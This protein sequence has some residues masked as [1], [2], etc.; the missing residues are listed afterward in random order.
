[1]CTFVQVPLALHYLG[2]EAYGFWVT[3]FSIVLVLNSVDFGLGVGMQHAMAKA[4]GRDDFDSMRRTFWTGA[5]VLSLLGLAVLL[6][7]IPLAQLGSWADVLQIRETRLRADVANA[8]SISV[9]AFVIGLPFNAVS[10]LAA[11]MQRGWIHAG[12]IAAGSGISLA[13]VAAAA[14]GRWGFLW[15][16]AASLLV[17]AIQ[18]LGLTVHLLRTLHWTPRPTSLAPAA[19][20]R[21]MLRSSLYFAFPQ[22]G[23]VLVQSVPAIAISVAAGSSAVTGYNLL[24]RLF[25]PF[26]QGQLI[27]LTPI[28][29]AYTEAHQRA[30]HSWVVRTFWRTV[31]AFVALAAGTAAVASHSHALLSLWVG[32]SADL[33]TPGLAAVVAAWC[34]VQ[35]AAQPFIHYMIGVGLLRRLAWASTPGFLIAATALFWGAGSGSAKGVL[36]AG[37]LALAIAVVPPLAWET[38]RA[39]GKSAKAS[40]PL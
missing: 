14:A 33:V 7:G 1:M 2:S 23:Q 8:L 36:D 6:V 39:V 25:S 28:W 26:Q 20:I 24:I 19:E 31:A 29:P 12:W 22:F 18:G 30:D 5:A 11:A 17:P 4:F 38:I 16:L 13:V 34:I 40:P 32:P 35:M 9:A 37:T 10:R 27:L 3:L 21:S 15:F